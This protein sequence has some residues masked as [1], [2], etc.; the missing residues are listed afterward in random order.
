MTRLKDL[1][2]VSLLKGESQVMSESLG[3]GLSEIINNI[4]KDARRVRSLT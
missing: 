2:E 1:R 3:V 4:T